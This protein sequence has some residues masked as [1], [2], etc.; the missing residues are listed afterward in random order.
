MLSLKVDVLPGDIK[1]TRKTPSLWYSPDWWRLR[2]LQEAVLQRFSER[3]R[4]AAED[5]PQLVPFSSKENRRS[6]GRRH[7]F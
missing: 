6:K 7:S 4:A 3:L 5:P 1:K 2:G